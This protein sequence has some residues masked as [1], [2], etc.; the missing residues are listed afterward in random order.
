M[1]AK[2]K[3]RLIVVIATDN[4]IFWTELNWTELNWIE[5]TSSKSMPTTVEQSVKYEL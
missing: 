4:K 5:T 2:K 3:I 1:W